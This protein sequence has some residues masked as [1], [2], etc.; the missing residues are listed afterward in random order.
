MLIDCASVMSVGDEMC[1]I[2]SVGVNAGK[3]DI[4]LEK[5]S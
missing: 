5:E 3:N 4:R 2:K 1:L